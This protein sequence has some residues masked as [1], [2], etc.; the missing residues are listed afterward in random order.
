[1]GWK[2]LYNENA[3]FLGLISFFTIKV[4]KA[5]LKSL[6]KIFDKNT[7]FLLIKRINYIINYWIN[8]YSFSYSLWDVS[9]ELDVFLNKLLWNFVKRRHSRKNNVWIYSKYWRFLMGRLYFYEVDPINGNICFLRS[10]CF[11]KSKIYRLPSSFNIHSIPDFNKLNLLWFRKVSFFF[12]GLY[13]LLYINQYGICP[14]CN[15]FI[16]RVSFTKIR[17][18]KIRFPVRLFSGK[19]S[20]LILLHS[21]CSEYLQHY[22]HNVG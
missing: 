22:I 4:H 12:I 3:I 17:I 11:V 7:I 1:M 9:G 13:K 14:Y 8:N 18:L 6:F 21:F 15:N 2:F 20:R 16:Y 5:N 10:H 19:F